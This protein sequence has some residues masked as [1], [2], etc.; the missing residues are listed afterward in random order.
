MT[1]VARRLAS[2]PVRTSIDT[3][4]AVVDMLTPPGATARADL[5]AITNVAALLISEEYTRDAPLIV[6]PRTG[7]RVRIYTVHGA[8]AVDVIHEETP[9]ATYPLHEPG[10]TLSLPCG[11]D[12]LDDI[13]SALRAFAYVTVRDATEGITNETAASATRH[14]HSLVI[15]TDEMRRP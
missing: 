7:A 10:W 12:D 9:L 11:I 6:T 8:D 15:N 3:W 13:Q 5:E 2:V 4:A 14:A 1:V